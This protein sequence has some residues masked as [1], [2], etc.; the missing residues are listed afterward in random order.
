MGKENIQVQVSLKEIYANVCPKC[1]NK[2]RMLV[3]DKLTDEM[4]NEVIM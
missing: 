1:K 2:L 4:V 3:K